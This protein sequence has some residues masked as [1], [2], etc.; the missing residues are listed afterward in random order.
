MRDVMGAETILAI[1]VGSQDVTDM[2]NYG[3]TLN[4]WWLLWKRWNP[5]SS[6]VRVPNLPEIQSRL[7]YV[8]CVKLLEEVKGSDYCTYIR[9]P[10]DK[11]KTL[12]F[13]SFDDIMDVGLNHGKVLF[14]AM[15]LGQQKSLHSL[16][17]KE[18]SKVQNLSGVQMDGH[19]TFTDLAERVCKIKDP[20][21]NQMSL[22]QFEDISED[23]DEY[24][25][26][27]DYQAIGTDTDTDSAPKL[28]QRKISTMF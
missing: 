12:Q 13:G 2:T 3:D 19:T 16:L 20:N 7:A 23:E 6:P 14:A 28:K 18:R 8:S 21:S 25:S 22:S 11:Y 27:P 26:E 4:G 5:F 17:H 9:P 10:I 1:D 24:M 15:R